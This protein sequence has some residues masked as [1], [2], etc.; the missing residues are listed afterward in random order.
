MKR[1][2][3]A[4]GAALLVVVTALTAAACSGGQKNTVPPI[5]PTKTQVVVGFSYSGSGAAAQACRSLADGYQ[6]WADT[7]NAKGGLRVGA[8]T[9]PVALRSYDDAGNAAS[10]AG[11]AERLITQDNVDLL[12]GP[13]G[14]SLT[15][16]VATVAERYRRVLMVTQPAAGA[17]LARRYGFIFDVSPA[18]AQFPVPAIAY[19]AARTPKPRLAVLW[20]DDATSE[21]AGNQAATL[22]NAAG[23]SVDVI[24]KYPTG[25]PDFAMH[26]ARIAADGATAVLLA[27]ASPDAATLLAAL[28]QSNAPAVTLLVAPPDG[29]EALPGALP[30]ASAD[31]FEVL[32][33]AGPA[34]AYND[35]LFGGPMAYA[36]AFASATGHTPNVRAALATAGAEVLGDAVV[37][38]RSLDQEA[39]RTALA[40]LSTT[41]VAG[42]FHAAADGGNAGGVMVL[43]R[44]AH[45]ALAVVYPPPAAMSPTPPARSPG[46]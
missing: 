29:W 1:T 3:D 23:L 18:A 44:V 4:V 34:A 19:L 28:Q 35:P 36:A 43:A 37:Q 9:L 16:A 38:A 42:A 17:T 7:V 5:P 32:P 20:A 40:Q 13:C 46:R 22:A 21:A 30:A 6:L 25:T 2:R 14:Q 27:G 15:D 41:T 33:W 11:N 45:G 24:G 39:L 10:A 12:L 8:R 31:V 26:A